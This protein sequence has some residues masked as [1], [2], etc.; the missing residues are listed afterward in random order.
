MHQKQKSCFVF[1]CQIFWCKAFLFSIFRNLSEFVNLNLRRLYI[2]S[3]ILLV[4]YFSKHLTF[5]KKSIQR[6]AKLIIK[7][8]KIAITNLLQRGPFRDLQEVN[9]KSSY[10][11]KG[12]LMTWQK[13][14][15]LTLTKNVIKVRLFLFQIRFLFLFQVSSIPFLVLVLLRKTKEALPLQKMV[16]IFC[17]KMLNKNKKC[18][19]VSSFWNKKSWN[20]TWLDLYKKCKTFFVLKSLTKIRS[21]FFFETLLIF[22]RLFLSVFQVFVRNL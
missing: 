15:N 10:D 3:G 7:V 14:L 6:K 1:F 8:V 13:K 17:F 19:F 4:K 2:F 9:K 12:I 21:V 22:V 18:I 20:L 16:Y 11:K 5:V